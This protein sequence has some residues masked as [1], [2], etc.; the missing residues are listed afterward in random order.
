MLKIERTVAH[1]GCDWV[2][3]WIH[4]YPAIDG[5]QVVLLQQLL[6]IGHP[7]CFSEKSMLR[8]EDG[9]KTWSPLLTVD[10]LRGYSRAGKR[11]QFIP[12]IFEPMGGGRFLVLVH[13]HTYAVTGEILDMR[14]PSFSCIY[15][16]RSN[17]WGELKPLD[18]EMKKA[19][20]VYSDSQI[21][22]EGE[23][24]LIPF[25][26]R[27]PDERTE[28]YR[29]FNL[30]SCVI[31]ARCRVSASGEL[32]VCEKS[33]LLTCSVPRGFAEPALHK[34]NGKY[35]LTLRN[36]E[37]AYITASDDWRKWPA[38]K[39]LEFEGGDWLGSY[40][41]MTK[42]AVLGGRL[43]LVYTRKGLNNDHVF[44]HRAPLL[45]AEV[46]PET[47]QVIRETEQILVPEYGSRLGN[48][49]VYQTSGNSACVTVAEWAEP[50]SRERERGANNR[51]WFVRVTSAENQ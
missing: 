42:L 34:L 5:D 16:I 24:W 33:D 48:F 12:G 51:I 45:I 37:T 9:G 10:G 38:P 8:S 19:C 35:F 15:D 22:Q 23:D 13:T 49:S 47:L 17:R 14:S 28:V 2:Y 7:D 29:Q 3:C 1:E 44:R 21:V 30:S 46:N 18:L 40:N 25:Y 20:D 32:K 11:T 36:D 4:P 41:T 6:E 27:F 31:I 39:R 43:Y 50:N 26:L